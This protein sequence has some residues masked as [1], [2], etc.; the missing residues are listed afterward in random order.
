[1]RATDHYLRP[2]LTQGVS[3]S[4]WEGRGWRVRVSPVLFVRACLSRSVFVVNVFLCLSCCVVV[5]CCLVL[6]CVVV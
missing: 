3:V 2:L 1:V 4:V 6:C 5:Y